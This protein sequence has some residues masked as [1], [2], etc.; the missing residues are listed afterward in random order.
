MNNIVCVQAVELLIEVMTDVDAANL[1]GQRASDIINNEKIKKKLVRAEA[2]V[3]SDRKVRSLMVSVNEW[4][5]R[6]TGMRVN[7]SNEIRNAYLIVATLIA[8]ATY[9]AALSP[10]G[11]F[12]E[13]DSAATNNTLIQGHGASNSSKVHE[14]K[15][16]MS[17]TNFLAFSTTNMF[18]FVTS[19]L[20]I[21]FLM[22][23]N[24]GW[25]LMYASSWL[26]VISYFFSMTVI[27][28]NDLT[29]NL[30]SSIFFVLLP[31]L[32]VASILFFMPQQ[33]NR[34]V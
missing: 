18:A 9:Q 27:S 29:T 16:V 10:P 8:T 20:T 2:R 6:K 12:H 33:E 19:I 34:I 23:R 26:L 24:V 13:I 25:F 32:A 4:L 15:S 28:P 21:I 17:N 31:I 5:I 7:M 14:G 22:P 30:M 1:G 3:R 11:G